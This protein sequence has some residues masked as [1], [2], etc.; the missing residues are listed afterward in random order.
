MSQFDAKSVREQ[1]SHGGGDGELSIIP[2]WS[3]FLAMI[4][5]AAAQY[6][7]HGVLPHQKAQWF[8]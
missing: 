7:F 1:N 2:A 3:I 5:F 4:V 6:L 8:L